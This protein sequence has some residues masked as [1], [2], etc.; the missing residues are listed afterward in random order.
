MHTEL[1]A[2][3]NWDCVTRGRVDWSRQH[4]PIGRLYWQHQKLAMTMV[5]GALFLYSANHSAG[6]AKPETWIKE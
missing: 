5:T 2:A 6:L 1:S 4:L 3:N